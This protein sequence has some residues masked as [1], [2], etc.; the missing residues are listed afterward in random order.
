MQPSQ[1][2]WNRGGFANNGDE[3]L[4]VVVMEA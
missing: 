1:P 2:D 3:A 4:R